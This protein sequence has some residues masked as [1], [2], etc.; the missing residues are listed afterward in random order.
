MTISNYRIRI[1]GI[2]AAAIWTE[3][4]T[5]SSSAQSAFQYNSMCIF[6]VTSPLNQVLVLVFG[7][8]CSRDSKPWSQRHKTDVS[9]S[10]W[11]N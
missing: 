9:K 4:C 3:H 1:A 10:T 8:E 5:L 11:H 7:F 6:F 2:H